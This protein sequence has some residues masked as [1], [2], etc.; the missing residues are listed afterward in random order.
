MLN[1]RSCQI[2]HVR[3]D[4]L[5]KIVVLALRKEILGLLI[6][7]QKAVPPP[8]LIRSGS[9]TLRHAVVVEVLPLQVGKRVCA[10]EHLR[11]EWGVLTD[12]D[13]LPIGKLIM[14]N[15]VPLDKQHPV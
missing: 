8:R 13:I 15:D 10:I 14:N 3:F 4:L 1:L 2:E 6:D 12:V 5:G 9:R 11:A 7:F